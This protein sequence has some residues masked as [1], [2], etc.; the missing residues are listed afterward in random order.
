MSPAVPRPTRPPGPIPLTGTVTDPD[1][2]IVTVPVDRQSPNSGNTPLLPDFGRIRVIFAYRTPAGPASIAGGECYRGPVRGLSIA[3]LLTLAGCKPAPT[4][5]PDSTESPTTE[6]DAPPTE[7]T[8]PNA[9]DGCVSL[10]ELAVA[11]DAYARG[12]S[13][14][15]ESRD[16][17][18]Y[19]TESFEEAIGALRTAAE[20]GHR[21]A[22]SLYGRTLFQVRFMNQ[23]P[24]P[25]EQEDYV[26]AF[27]FMRVAALRGD[28]EM[29]GYLPGLTDDAP[30]VEQP[31]YDSIPPEW[32]TEA[33]E[34]ADAWMACHGEAAA[35]R[36]T[37]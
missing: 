10:V 8:A 18:H 13:T 25:P 6:G 19:R 9:A 36:G 27:A 22:Q 15:A 14:L 16:G 37:K 26:S 20:G 30:P 7:A 2:G 35:D 5:P 11:D 1:V 21:G 34:R 32:L 3:V 24:T 23:G 28:P 17:E 29:D 4:I 31:P 12:V 33:Y